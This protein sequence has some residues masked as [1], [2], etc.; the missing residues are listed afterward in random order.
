MV[1]RENRVLAAFAVGLTALTVAAAVVVAFGQPPLPPWLGPWAAAVGVLLFAAG[2]FLV[3]QA[4][5]ARYVDDGVSRR[6][7]L[8]L[9]AGATGL[10]AL[11]VA[12]TLP[13]PQRHVVSGFGVALFVGLVGYEFLA[14]YRAARP[15]GE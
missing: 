3:P 8:R 5:L 15:A 10:A 4:Y 9:G 13:V 2:L 7:R 14:G 11:A 6:A 1:S 12:G